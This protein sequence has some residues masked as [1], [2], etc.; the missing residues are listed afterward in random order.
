MGVWAVIG[1]RERLPA[2]EGRRC[3]R[4]PPAGAHCRPDPGAL[5]CSERE[6]LRLFAFYCGRFVSA[7]KFVTRNFIRNPIQ[8]NR[9]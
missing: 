3:E 7:H 8:S 9:S 5:A 6:L 2:G 1:G 4:W